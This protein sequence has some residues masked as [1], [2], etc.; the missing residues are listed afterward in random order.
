[1]CFY[2]FNVNEIHSHICQNNGYC[3]PLVK[4][5]YELSF[6]KFKQNS[7]VNLWNM[8][9]KI[10]VLRLQVGVVGWV[11][12]LFPDNHLRNLS[13][14]VHLLALEREYV[15]SHTSVAVLPCANLPSSALQVAL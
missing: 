9:M 15:S 1:M 2:L 8:I 3:F 7:I 6:I 14:Q 5:F 12:N 4:Q 11:K 13:S 10:H